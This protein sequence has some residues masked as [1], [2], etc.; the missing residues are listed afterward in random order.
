MKPFTT[1]FVRP[2]R[3]RFEYKETQQGGQVYRYIIWA[4][5]KEVKTWW[6]I[7]PGIETPKSLEL[8]LGAAVGVSSYSSINISELLMPELMGSHR[9][10]LNEPK[11]AEDGKLDKVE[12]Y[13]VE[14]KFGSEPI[15]VWID[16]KSNLVRRID[17]QAKFNDFR[18]EQSTT[19]NPTINEKV[20]DKMLRSI[21]LKRNDA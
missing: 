16:K 6:D 5:A 3:F 12:Y 10:V 13:R 1:A 19:Y 20:T 4:N 21:R 11:R 17:E 7:R 18:T 15:T 2:D 9:L 8:A 14:G